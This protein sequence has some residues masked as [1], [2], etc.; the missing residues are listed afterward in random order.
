VLTITTEVTAYGS[1]NKITNIA[2]VGTDTNPNN[3]GEA[4]QIDTVA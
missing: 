1:S 2:C 3:G 4:D